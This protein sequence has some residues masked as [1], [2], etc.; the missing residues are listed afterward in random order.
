MKKKN[1]LF[2]FKERKAIPRTVPTWGLTMCRTPAHQVL[3][4]DLS[5]FHH[6]P[7]GRVLGVAFRYVHVTLSKGLLQ[8]AP[9]KAGTN[10]GRTLF[11][12]QP[13]KPALRQRDCTQG[14]CPGRKLLP[15]C[16]CDSP[17]RDALCTSKAEMSQDV[18]EQNQRRGTK[19]WT[20]HASDTHLTWS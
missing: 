5:Q 11:R 9:E 12:D 3:H 1:S 20:Q 19:E 4:T 13:R 15:F 6:K 14:G 17:C 8:W 10:K 7:T 2:L 16:S 18:G